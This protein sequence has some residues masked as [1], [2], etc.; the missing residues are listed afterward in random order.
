VLLALWSPLLSHL[1]QCCRHPTIVAMRLHPPTACRLPYAVRFWREGHLVASAVCE[2]QHT[3]EAYALAHRLAEAV[4]SDWWICGQLWPLVETSTREGR[5]GQY[6][7][8]AKVA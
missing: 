6:A 3:L 7:E 4:G 5:G 8:V 1:R 2:V